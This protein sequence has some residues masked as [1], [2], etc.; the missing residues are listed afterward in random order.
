MG[1]GFHNQGS[2]TRRL[3]FHSLKTSRSQNP[4]TRILEIYVKDFM[5]FSHIYQPEGL[6][7]TSLSQGYVLQ[8][9]WAMRMMGGSCIPRTRVGEKPPI[10]GCCS[11]VNQRLCPF[12][13][14]TQHHYTQ[15]FKKELSLT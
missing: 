1:G 8:M 7:N 14:L 4:P 6:N 2:L 11:S 12:N 15:F 5:G 3:V 10:S 13:D 9:A